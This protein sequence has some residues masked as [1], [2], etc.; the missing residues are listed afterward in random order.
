MHKHRNSNLFKGPEYRDLWQATNAPQGYPKFQFPKLTLH[1]ALFYNVF[2]RVIEKRAT[3]LPK[4]KE[5]QAAGGLRC[6]PGTFH[7]GR[8]KQSPFL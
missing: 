5:G 1:P 4:R 7:M 6:W 2:P 8:I 3:S